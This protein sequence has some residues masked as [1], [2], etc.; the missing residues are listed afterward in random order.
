[1]IAHNV[2]DQLRLIDR[3]VTTLT[4]STEALLRATDE[5]ALLEDICRI[6]VDVAGYRLAWVGYAL[7]DEPKSV[8]PVAIAGRG[9]DYLKETTVSWSDAELGQGPIGTAIRTGRPQVVHDTAQDPHFAPWRDAA[10]RHHFRSVLS[11]PLGQD[12]DRIGTLNIYAAER[13]AFDAEVIRLMEDL[14]RNLTYGIGA[15]R[16]KAEHEQAVRDLAES[17]ERYRSIIELTPDAI[18]V[19]SQGT[20]LFANPTSSRVFAAGPQG[21]LG[22]HVL[23]LIHDDSHDEVSRRIANPP[24]QRQVS[25]YRMVRLDG[26]EFDAEIAATTITFHGLP[27]R[28]L[29]IR[30]A[31]DRKQVQQQLVQAAKLATLGEMAAGLVHELSQPLNIIRLTAEGALLF[32]ERGKATPEWQAQQFQLVADQ[33]QRTAEIIDDIRIFSRRDTGPVQVFDAIAA[34]TSALGVLEGQLRPD[35]I[36]LVTDLP[37]QPILI[38]G[39]RVQL[40][41]VVMNLLSNAQHALKEKREEGNPGNAD[42]SAEI[43]V[44]ARRRGRN[45][46]ITVADSG[47]GIPPAVRAR[48]FEPF[49]TTKEAGR[50]T[51]LGLSVSFGIITSMGGSLEVVERPGG[52]CFAITLPVDEDS[53]L[54][55]DE[56]KDLVHDAIAMDS[57]I[58]VVEDE[59]T[60]GETLGRYLNELGYRVSVCTNGNEAWR[61]FSADPADVVITD[62]RM[63]AG[64]GEQLVEKLRD[65]DPL[66]PIVIVTGHLG[67]TERLAEN[68][69]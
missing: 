5:T 17:E 10:L 68:L 19:H 12:T 43:T 6:A 64:G 25:E 23:D 49:F 62:L 48:I 7:P 26:T 45:L 53:T 24:I 50:G 28:I 31:T 9:Q 39:R 52:A 8:G 40:E 2:A 69:N 63:P 37:C 11:L 18:I 30:D 22:R 27:A 38:R 15:L 47:P 36:N 29:V 13:D 33:A 59:Q 1:M 58:M 46:V 56:N 65:F 61:L 55:A 60:A 67:A 41:Q 51:G 35:D 4:R 32:I 54:A 66:M 42:W 34:A 57:H 14:A 3:A 20:I 44:S 16:M 21:L